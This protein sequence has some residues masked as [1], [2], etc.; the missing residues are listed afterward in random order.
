MMAVKFGWCPV[1]IQSTVY[2]TAHTLT[3][4]NIY[5]ICKTIPQNGISSLATRNPNTNDGLPGLI[6][7]FKFWQVGLAL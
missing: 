5:M 4:E 3:L 6:S 7:S 1:P 2:L